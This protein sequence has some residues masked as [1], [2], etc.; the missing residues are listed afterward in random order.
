MAAAPPHRTIRLWNGG[1]IG[2]SMFQ[3]NN[4]IGRKYF[5]V[6]GYSR[7]T[8]NFGFC[9]STRNLYKRGQSPSNWDGWNGKPGLILPTTQL[10]KGSWPEKGGMGNS[11]RTSVAL[12]A[13]LRVRQYPRKL[14]NPRLGNFCVADVHLF[15]C[16]ETV[17]VFQTCVGK[18]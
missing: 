15:E 10:Q 1:F 16:A 11:H 9:F 12:T 17:K 5:R 2:S 14:V 13:Y 4:L 7:P 18:L 8:R 6:I 3:S